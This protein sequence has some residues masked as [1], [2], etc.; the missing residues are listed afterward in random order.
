MDSVA[1]EVATPF[2][3][4]SPRRASTRMGLF[5]VPYGE[6]ELVNNVEGRQRCIY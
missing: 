3:E 1:A 5:T 6:R 2:F 4:I